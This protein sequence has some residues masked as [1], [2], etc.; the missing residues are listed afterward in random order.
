MFLFLGLTVGVIMSFEFSGTYSSL[1][2]ISFIA[3]KHEVLQ[4]GFL[5]QCSNITLIQPH[6]SL[7]NFRGRQLPLFQIRGI[8]EICSPQLCL[9]THTTAVS[10]YLELRKPWKSFPIEKK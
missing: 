7:E 9:E 5:L 10:C 3:K 6:L 2:A 4:P 1:E 8:S